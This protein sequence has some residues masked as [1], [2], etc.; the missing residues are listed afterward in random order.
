MVLHPH[1][2]QLYRLQQQTEAYGG[3]SSHLW[4]FLLFTCLTFMNVL[5]LHSGH[6]LHAMRLFLPLWNTPQLRTFTFICVTAVFWRNS[7]VGGICRLLRG[8]RDAR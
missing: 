4:D 7:E 2:P 1:S 3:S 5:S 6:V 8:H